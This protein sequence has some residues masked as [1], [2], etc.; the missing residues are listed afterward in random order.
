MYLLNL[1][2]LQVKQGNEFQFCCL[3]GAGTAPCS[4]LLSVKD[5]EILHGVWNKG[6]MNIS[7]LGKN[8]GFLTTLLEEKTCKV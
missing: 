7:C 4:I 5:A 8:E 1:I 2:K 3:Q 6:L